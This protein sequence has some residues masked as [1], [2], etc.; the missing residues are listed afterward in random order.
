[1]QFVGA[2][3]NRGGRAGGVRWTIEDG[4]VYDARQ[5]LDDVRR[6]VEQAKEARGIEADADL[7]LGK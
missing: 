3:T 2:Y 5:L 7:E 6:M 1:M 4:I